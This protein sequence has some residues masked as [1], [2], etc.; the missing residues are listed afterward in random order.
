MGK[1]RNGRHARTT[2]VGA[3]AA[4][5]VY[6]RQ[7]YQRGPHG[8]PSPAPPSSHVVRPQCCLQVGRPATRGHAHPAHAPPRPLPYTH[9]RAHATVLAPVCPA[10]REKTHDRAVYPSPRPH[11][12]TGGERGKY[13]DRFTH[14]R[15]VAATLVGSGPVWASLESSMLSCGDVGGEGGQYDPNARNVF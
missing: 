13:V 6:P 7:P 2:S 10:L 1:W 3:S 11:D 12:D 8:P 15:S 4:C 5:D 14:A 9:L